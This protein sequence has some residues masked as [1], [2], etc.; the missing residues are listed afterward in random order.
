MAV[1]LLIDISSLIITYEK[2]HLLS[3]NSNLFV[4]DSVERQIDLEI[5]TRVSPV[6]SDL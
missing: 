5:W 2:T 1:K 3:F 4:C 6:G